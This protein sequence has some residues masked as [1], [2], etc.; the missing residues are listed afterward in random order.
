MDKLINAV[1]NSLQNKNWYAALFVALSLP[2]IC[3]R[4]ENPTSKSLERYVVWFNK[5]LRNEYTRGIGPF[6]K[7]IVTFLSGKDCY[8]LRCAYL[9]E[10]RDEITDQRCQQ[11]LNNFRF[12]TDLS[13]RNYFNFNNN[14]ILQLNVE[15]FCNEISL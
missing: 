3:G 7:K 12:T 2:D 10:G 11:V 4:L 6:G 14:A 1:E 9:H 8:A 13:H 5:Y 15:I